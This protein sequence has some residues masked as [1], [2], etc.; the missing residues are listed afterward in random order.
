MNLDSLKSIE[1]VLKIT[2]LL[3]WKK[4]K[5]TQPVILES[6]LSRGTSSLQ[7]E[8]LHSLQKCLGTRMS[9]V[10]LAKRKSKM[11]KSETTVF[12]VVRSLS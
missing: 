9:G 3:F 11:F 7:S 5:D 1:S 2:V 6:F 8:G 10:V 4:C 12:T